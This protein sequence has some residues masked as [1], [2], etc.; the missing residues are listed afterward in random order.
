MK[1]GIIIIEGCDG[2]GK[3]TLAR[4][5]AKLLG[6]RYHHEG[7]PTQPAFEY[8]MNLANTLE[9]NVVMDRAHLGELVYPRVKPQEGR[10]GLMLWEQHAIE[11]VLTARGALLVHAQASPEWILNVFRE[12]GEEYMTENE[13]EPVSRLFRHAVGQTVLHYAGWSVED[14]IDDPARAREVMEHIADHATT[15]RRWAQALQRYGGIGELAHVEVALVGE[16]VSPR[17]GTR[18]FDRAD[19]ASRFLHQTLGHPIML[20]HAGDLY[21]TNALDAGGV[22]KTPEALREELELVNP[23][24]TVALGKRAHR[25]LTDIGWAHGTVHHPQYVRRFKHGQQDDYANT[26]N[27][28]ILNQQLAREAS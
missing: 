26:L 20:R 10:P 8:Y 18:A 19:G 28:T 23:R 13:V 24:V 17:G 16:A 11:R 1:N 27:S 5:L 7:K 12:R 25:R 2:T 4:A 21:L 14:D 22:D 9:G 6:W 15:R 3:S